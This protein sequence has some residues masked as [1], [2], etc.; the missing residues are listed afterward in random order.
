MTDSLREAGVRRILAMGDFNEDL[1]GLGGGT[2]K[3]NGAWELID[4]ALVLGDFTSARMGLFDDS[5]LST[6]DK[7]FGGTKPRRTFTGP[8]YLGGISDHYPIWVVMDY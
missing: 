2:I 5:S 1:W 8:A 6:R 7:G 3:Y 4:R